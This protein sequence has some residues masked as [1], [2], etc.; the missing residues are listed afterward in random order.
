MVQTSSKTEALLGAIRMAFT[1]ARTAKN[2]SAAQVADATQ[3]VDRVTVWRLEVE[4]KHIPKID[5]L[6]KIAEAL[7]TP[8]SRIIA[9]AERKL[10]EVTDE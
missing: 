6:I 2:L 8:L 3:G 4:G 5:L 7:G 10:E 1:D 9:D